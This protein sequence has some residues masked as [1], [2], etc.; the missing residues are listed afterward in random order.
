MHSFEEDKILTEHRF[1]VSKANIL[2]FIWISF[3]EIYNEN[4]YDLLE[5]MH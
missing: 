3:V 5:I 1:P 4:V 2:V